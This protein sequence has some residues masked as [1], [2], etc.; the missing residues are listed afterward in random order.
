MGSLRTLPS[1]VFAGSIIIFWRHS[2]DRIIYRKALVFMLLYCIY[3]WQRF[4]EFL[5]GGGVGVVNLERVQN[6]HI[7]IIS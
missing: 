3:C 2:K 5:I 6:E 4:S 1:F 7:S